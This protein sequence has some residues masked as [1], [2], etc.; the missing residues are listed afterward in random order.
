[1]VTS[2]IVQLLR[3]LNKNELAKFRE[4][5]CSPYFNKKS[6]LTE[7][8][9]SLLKYSPEFE[10]NKEHTITIYRKLYQGS[11]FN[12]Q[13]YK[14]L[15]SE[16]YSLARQ[17][18]AVNLYKESELRQSLDLLRKLELYGADELYKTEIK[19]IRKKLNESKF[20]DFLFLH[21]FE[22]FVIERSFLY[23]RSRHK[24][25]MDMSIEESDELL[26]FYLTH[27][28][29]ERFDYEST[30][31]SFNVK[32][33]EN[34]AMAHI[35]ELLHKGIVQDTVNK[36]EV[37]KTRDREII[38]LFYYILMSF[39]YPD[40][41]TYFNKAKDLVFRN[42]NKFD[43]ATAFEVS[44]ALYSLFTFKL[45]LAGN[46]EDYRNTFEIINFRLKKK[47]YKEDESGFINAIS[48]RAIFMTASR[49]GEFEWLKKFHKK[50][51]GEVTPEHRENL[52]NLLLSFIKFYDKQFESSLEYSSLVKY[53]IHLY[54]LDV[55]KLQLMNYYELNQLEPALSLV[56]SFREFLNSNKDLTEDERTKHLNLLMVFQKLL[57]LR[58]EFSG[59]ESKKLSDEL[60]KYE[61]LLHKGWIEEKVKELIKENTDF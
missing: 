54:K 41:K 3:R 25:A 31:L 43:K 49:L 44:G 55:R 33:E 53:D 10:L 29:R 20:Y 24:K 46:I 18:T 19:P 50:Y 4:F 56:S 1:M 47:I 38:A 39:K 26:K 28:F 21:K 48:F 22:L 35:G 13:V 40:N 5:L 30:G 57:K 32:Y 16:L 12:A 36:M 27:A 59:Y 6:K 61:Q 52:N 17:F 37:R 7:F 51:I 9:D 8:Y 45:R 15:S 11:K 34:P 2:K 23:N 14:N 60:D 42:I 58:E